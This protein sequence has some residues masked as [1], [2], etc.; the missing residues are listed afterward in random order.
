MYEA[1]KKFRVAGR[2]YKPGDPVDPAGWRNAGLLERN[3]Y[4][5]PAREGAPREESDRAGRGRGKM[6]H[7]DANH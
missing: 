2:D 7:G 5:R 6:K 3:G 1:G 4:I